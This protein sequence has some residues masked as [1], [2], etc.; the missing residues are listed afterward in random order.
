MSTFDIEVSSRDTIPER[1]FLIEDRL[2]FAGQID[3]VIPPLIKPVTDVSFEIGAFPREG[4]PTNIPTYHYRLTPTPA[5]RLSE[6]KALTAFTF[7]LN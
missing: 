4:W 3:E 5:D 1:T 7:L 2:A 6:R